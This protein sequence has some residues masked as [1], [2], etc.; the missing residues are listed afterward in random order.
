MLLFVCVCVCSTAPLIDVT[1]VSRI[2]EDVFTITTQLYYTGGG[3]ITQFTVS[4]RIQGEV[5]WNSAT[6]VP[7]KLVPESDGLTWT[8]TVTSSEFAVFSVVEFQVLVE[9]EQSLITEY[10]G[11]PLTE[12]QG[13]CTCACVCVCV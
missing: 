9:N 2:K 11:T 1:T 3:I 7:A 6:V 10:D 8:G 4:F 5:E 12:T 13:V